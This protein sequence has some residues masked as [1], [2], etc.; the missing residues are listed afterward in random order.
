MAGGSGT[1]Q[2]ILETARAL[3]RSGG[4]GNLTFDA[5]AR[6]LGISKQAVLYWFPRKEDLVAGVAVPLLREE[7]QAAL[8]AMK[9]AP[10]PS[11]AVSAFVKAVAAF[12]FADLDRF[13]LMYVAPQLG[14][15][16]TIRM[17]DRLEEQIH[18]LTSSMYDALQAQLS[19]A[20]GPAEAESRRQA[21]AIH[22]SVLGLVMIVA[23]TDAVG[24]P[25][26]HDK[27][28]LAET[29]ARL[30]SSQGNVAKPG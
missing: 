20:A 13:R 3:I 2:K 23:L 12:H 1:R 25:L 29:L 27:E 24:D 5:V 8:S 22:M 21:V 15:K 19:G 14:A 26:L 4:P 9:A 11:A 17:T 6:R 7:A 18:S 10:N 30:L 16:P 28:D